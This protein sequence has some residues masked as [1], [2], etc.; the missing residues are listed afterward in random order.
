ML[1]TSNLFLFFLWLTTEM[2]I[3]NSKTVSA[4]RKLMFEILLKIIPLLPSYQQ[5]VD[6]SDEN[7]IMIAKCM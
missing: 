3:T 6:N 7:F 2:I 5:N 1:F 4:C